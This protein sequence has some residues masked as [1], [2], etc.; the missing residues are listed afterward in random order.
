MQENQSVNR[1][2]SGKNIIL[3]LVILLVVVCIITLVGVF[4]LSEETVS[5]EDAQKVEEV[6]SEESETVS[7]KTAESGGDIESALEILINSY[8]KALTVGDADKVR[9]VCPSY[10]EQDEESLKIQK[11]YYESY[12]NI[13]FIYEPGLYED[14][15]VVFIYYEVKFKNIDTLGP[16][17]ITTYVRKDHKGEYYIDN[18]IDQDRLEYVAKVAQN[19]EVQEM[20]EKAQIKFDDALASDPELEKMFNTLTREMEKVK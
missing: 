2:V 8:Y 17:A 6:D 7:K 12:E 4:L 16:G 1:S 20:M 14:E 19:K 10:S 15:Y 18:Y 13:S 9:K 5:E 11:R 3:Y